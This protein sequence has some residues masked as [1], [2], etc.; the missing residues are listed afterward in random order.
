MRSLLVHSP[1][2]RAFGHDRGGLPAFAEP[3]GSAVL[4]GSAGCDIVEGGGDSGGLLSGVE[5]PPQW[6]ATRPKALAY[7][8]DLTRRI[9]TSL[10]VGPGHLARDIVAGDTDFGQSLGVRPKA[11]AGVVCNVRTH[12]KHSRCVD[13]NQSCCRLSRHTRGG[14]TRPVRER[15]ARARASV[16]SSAYKNRARFAARDEHDQGRSATCDA[17]SITRV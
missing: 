12:R 6:T 7:A 13:G 16:A 15:R 10:L 1:P 2:W 14:L 8:E 4:P 17:A 9:M 5:L 3:N 11:S